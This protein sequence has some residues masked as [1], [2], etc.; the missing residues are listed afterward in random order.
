MKGLDMNFTQSFEEFSKG[1]S[2][3]D[4][5]LYAGVGLVV[6][7]LF[8]DKLS[9]VQ[10]L[11]KTA[12]DSLKNVLTKKV[13]TVQPEQRTDNVPA[14]LVQTIAENS[15]VEPEDFFF[16]LIVSWKETRDLAL[17]CGCEKAVNVADEMF[18]YLSPSVCGKDNS[19]E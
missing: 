4:L 18:P 16:K 19:N 2:S 13:T 1:L 14:V 3:T 11:L 9:P 15:K 6:W 17:K 8:K 12:T 10:N 7:V 5:M